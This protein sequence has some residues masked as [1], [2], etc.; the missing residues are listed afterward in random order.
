MK[1]TTFS[2]LIGFLNACQAFAWCA[3]SSHRPVVSTQN[4]H[5]T[6]R[7]KGEYDD[8]T[9]RRSRRTF[10]SV[11][12]ICRRTR[13]SLARTLSASEQARRD[14]EQRKLEREGDVVPGKTSALPGAQDF[15]LNP[16][17]TEEEYLRQASNL[18]QI[19]YKET[20]RGLEAL[21]MLRIDEA[22]QC[23][24]KV[25]EARPNAYC[26]QAG[27]ARFYSGDLEDAADIFASNAVIYEAKFGA[28]ASEERIWRHACELKLRTS[29]RRKD[30][31]LVDETGAI[32]TPIP[33]KDNTAELLKS[34]TRKVIR[35]ALDLFSASTKLDF[36]AVILS[37]AKLLAIAMSPGR[38]SKGPILDRKM[39]KLSS[40][41]YLGL[42]YDAIGDVEQSKRCMKRSILLCPNSGGCSDI[43]Y[44]LPFIHMSQR[45]WFDDEEVNPADA[46][47][48]ESLH[49]E[50]SSHGSFEVNPIVI[51]SV[52]SSLEALRTVD[53]Q[54]TLKRR[55]LPATGSK[56]ELKMRLFRSIVEEAGIGLIYESY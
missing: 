25:F 41:Y 42:H 5:S 9:E 49:G 18:E 31:K 51:E 36:S 46:F 50:A 35:I 32:L 15:A 55:G 4:G 8:H 23:F 34:E 2:L 20:E 14:E 47:D 19:V 16:S 39:W 44:S 3:T 37:R 53:L 7:Q 33:A 43:L 17:A 10:I 24:D 48:A 40:W 52:K 56:D 13:L 26:W 22:N 12:R 30:Q 54:Q 21:K 45:E 27:I 11:Q 1:K 29:M 28:P 38:T 6:Q